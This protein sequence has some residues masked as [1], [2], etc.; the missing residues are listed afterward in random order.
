MGI[1]LGLLVIVGV[2]LLSH[3]SSMMY[4]KVK[5]LSGGRYESAYELAYALYGRRAIFFVCVVQYM[6]NF[7]GIVLYFIVLSDAFTSITISVVLGKDAPLGAEAKK[8][9]LIQES[10]WA[11]VISHR[12]F[13]IVAIGIALTSIIF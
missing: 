12:A 5:D 10:S 6:L 11:Q 3:I 2:A 4:I 1:W 8:E 13:W 7:A 9:Q